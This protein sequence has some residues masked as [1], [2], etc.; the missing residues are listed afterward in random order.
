MKIALLGYGKMGKMVEQL[1]L[2]DHHEVILKVNS[3]SRSD[4]TVEQLKGADA[5]IEFSS[6]Q[7]V[8]N[9]IKLC[10]DAAVPM[11]VGTT[12]WQDYLPE[13]KQWCLEKN[14]SIIYASNFS[15]GVNI[16]F[17]INRRLA[18]LMKSRDEYNVKITE[19]HHTEKKDAP[20]GTAISIAND[21]L[22]ESSFKTSWVN[23]ETDNSS[24]LIILSRREEN[25]IGIHAIE[26]SSAVDSIEI[27][28]EAFSREGF[29][30][31][32]I[33]AAQWLR[34][35]QGFFEFSEILDK[36]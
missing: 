9:N 22:R 11:V 19:T 34:G 16:F 23:H 15:V 3:S 24:E 2:R 18:E 13:V 8:L 12:G 26:Y 1:L 10:L 29:A 21:I 27:K 30:R 31:G 14:G 17:N 28:H 20:S 4:L 35:K 7:S 5:V 25:V 33:L 32:A 6:P 36:I